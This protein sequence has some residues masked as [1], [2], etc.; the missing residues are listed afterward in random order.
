[1]VSTPDNVDK[2]EDAGVRFMFEGEAAIYAWDPC[3]DVTPAE[4]AEFIGILPATILC[5][6]KAMPTKVVD[7]L[8]AQSSDGLRRHIKSKQKS[9]IVLP[10]RVNGR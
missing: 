7:A 9:S 4:L 5:S 8:V 6:I 2:P 3:E 1:M 10:S